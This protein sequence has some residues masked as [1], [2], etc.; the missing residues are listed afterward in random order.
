[1]VKRILVVCSGNICRSPLAKE[2][3]AQALPNIE[4]DSA[5]VLVD[6]TGLKGKPAVG[7]SQTLAERKGLTLSEHKAKQVTPDLVEWSDLILV[8]SHD[9]ID[10]VSELNLGTRAKTLLIGQ[11]IGVGEVD[12]PL[13]KDIEE[14]EHCYRTLARAIES[15]RTRLS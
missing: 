6:K 11:W 14:F 5:G 7:H 1:M 15:W 3:F 9:H 13:G 12:D 8:M 4:F 2:L 10:L